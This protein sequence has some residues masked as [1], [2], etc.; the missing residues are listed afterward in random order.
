MFGYPEMP[1]VGTGGHAH[2][3]MVIMTRWRLDPGQIEVVDDAVAEALRRK[4]PGQRM[5]MVSAGWTFARRWIA[6]AVRSQHPDWDQRQVD[7]EV[8]RRLQPWNRKNS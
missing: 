1:T 4:T 6:A 3:M 7:D 2:D 5:L 8:K